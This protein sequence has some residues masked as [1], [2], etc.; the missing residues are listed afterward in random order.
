MK[1][2]MSFIIVL[3]LLSCSAD[4]QIEKERIREF[5]TV[6]GKRETKQLDDIVRDFDSFLDKKYKNKNSD[7]RLKQYLEEL[8]NWNNPELWRIDEVKLK[9]YHTSNLFA[10]YDSLYPDSVWIEDGM[11]NIKY[12]ELEAIQSIIPINKSN[13]DSM[14]NEFKKEPEL[15][16]TSPSSFLLALE[17][18][19]QKDSQLVNYLDAKEIAG[20]IPLHILANGLLYN[21]KNSSEYFTKRILV[22][23]MND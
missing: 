22:M 12:K 10:K 3:F 8:A 14:V 19:A 11:V 20:N 1:H 21:Y 13:I 23:E 4:K 16:Q 7:S 18:I 9:R 5:K 2:L 15:N 6:L 17:S